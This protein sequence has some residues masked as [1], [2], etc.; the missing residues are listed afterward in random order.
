MSEQS[1]NVTP[2]QACRRFAYRDLAA[3][4]TLQQA[5]NSPLPLAYLHPHFLSEKPPRPPRALK[6]AR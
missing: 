5:Q 3:V 1:G 4:E 6:D 2:T